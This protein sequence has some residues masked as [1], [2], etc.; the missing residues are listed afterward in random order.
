[1][2]KAKVKKL[3]IDLFSILC[4]IKIMIKDWF[5]NNKELFTNNSLN[6]YSFLIDCL[7]QT[8][9]IDLLDSKLEVVRPYSIK[10]KQKNQYNKAHESLSLEGLNLNNQEVSS[11]SNEIRPKEQKSNDLP[12]GDISFYEEAVCYNGVRINKLKIRYY[13]NTFECFFTH[14]KTGILQLDKIMIENNDLLNI[15]YLNKNKDKIKKQLEYRLE[16]W[17][18]EYRQNASEKENLIDVC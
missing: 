1:M 13:L 4:I 11:S 8:H 5:E 10:S 15:F 14:S 2:Q 9:N 16:S 3:Y 18:L 6:G 12:T 7:I 17:L